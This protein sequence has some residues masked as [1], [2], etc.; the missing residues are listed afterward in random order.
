M[1]HKLS[2]PLCGSP[3]EN[4]GS[5]LRCKNSHEF[6]IIDGIPSFAETPET[7]EP[8]E[9]LYERYD[10]RY[11][12]HKT[13]F[14]NELKAIKALGIDRRD[15]IEIGVGTGR[16]AKALGIPYG[17]DA[18]LNVLRI[19]VSRGIKVVHALAERMPF[20]DKAFEN[21]LI[22]FTICFV[23]DPKKTLE[24]AKRISRN[25][26]I[27]AI[28]PRESPRGRYYES[29]RSESPFYSIARFYSVDE[30]VDLMGMK[31]EK[32]YSTLFSNPPEEREEEPLEGIYKEAGFVAMSFK[33]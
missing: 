27:L 30:I 14:E 32:A 11:D 28:V 31:P 9:R 12:R 13:L 10:S 24:E 17:L 15:S 1:L 23:K 25:R 29:K 4:I 18:S 8:F 6:P 26:I 22:A 2:C 21:T 20:K 16:F 7:A 3:L 19:A 5:R 33:I